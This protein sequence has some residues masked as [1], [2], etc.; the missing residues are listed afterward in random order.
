MVDSQALQ[1]VD[2]VV[3]RTLHFMFGA[4]RKPLSDCIQGL[5]NMTTYPQKANHIFESIC[6]SVLEDKCDSTLKESK[7]MGVLNW[8]QN[9][10][11]RKM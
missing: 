6:A 8:S 1:F 10:N 2:L 11:I 4:H 5:F 9:Q 7:S 3:F